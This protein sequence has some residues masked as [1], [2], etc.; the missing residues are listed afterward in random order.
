MAYVIYG[1]LDESMRGAP[2]PHKAGECCGNVLWKDVAVSADGSVVVVN[3][4]VM[5][6][7]CLPFGDKGVKLKTGKP[8][9]DRG[10]SCQ[11]YERFGYVGLY[12]VEDHTLEEDAVEIDT[13]MFTESVVS[14]ACLPQKP[15]DA[16]KIR[17]RGL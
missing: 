16:K 5:S 1:S 4:G 7:L 13:D 15:F 17:R 11:E 12:L 9:E 6:S 14:G 2:R 3:K 10:F 8:A